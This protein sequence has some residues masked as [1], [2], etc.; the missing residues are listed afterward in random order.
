[1]WFDTILT[2]KETKKFYARSNVI[3]LLLQYWIIYLCSDINALFIF[4]VF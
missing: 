3:C 2:T 4:S 1:M